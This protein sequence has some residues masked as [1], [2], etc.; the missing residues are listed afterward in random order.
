MNY[1]T[2]KDFFSNSNFNFD[3]LEIE[4]RL[5]YIRIITRL[6]PYYPFLSEDALTALVKHYYK[7]S[8]DLDLKGTDVGKFLS[9]KSRFLSGFLGPRNL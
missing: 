7:S 3:N 8:K 1:K 9:R 5:S 6:I 4:R 2:V